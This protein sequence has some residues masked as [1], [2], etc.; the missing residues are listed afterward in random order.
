MKKT[1]GFFFIIIISSFL[2]KISAQNRQVI[3]AKDLT[4]KDI[5]SGVCSGIKWD[6]DS[7]YVEY[8]NNGSSF[9][10]DLKSL[11]SEKTG[12]AKPEEPQRR[13]FSP[14]IQMGNRQVAQ[15]ARGRQR[16]TEI[17]PDG[18]WFAVCRDWN[19]FLENDATGEKIQV[20]P[21]G[22]HKFRY[23]TANWVYGE[24]LP[25]VRNGM[26]W[27][28]DSKKLIYFVFDERPVRDFYLTDNLTGVISSLNTEGYTKAGDPI[29]IVWLEIYD[30]MTAKRIAIDCGQNLQDQYI[31]NI[32]F[33]PDGKEL[34][35][36]RCDRL[37][38]YVEVVALDYN[39]GKTRIVVKEE[40][41]TWQEN[42]P[43]MEY[44]SD[45]KRFIWLTEK[46]MW[47]NFE[48]RSLDGQLINKLTNNNYP[49]T[50][51]VKI[52]EKK[53][54]LYYKACSESNPLIEQ[55]FVVGL[56]GKGQKKISD[57]ALNYTRINFSPDNDYY[58]AQ[59]E[60]INTPPSTAL[61]SAEGKLLKVLAEGPAVEDNLTELFTFKSNDGKFDIYGLLHKPKSF[62]PSKK[63]PVI[64]SVYGG[65]DS[66]AIYNTFKNGSAQYGDKEYLMVQVDNRG[67]SGRGKAFKAAVYR[68]L[69]DVDIQDQADAIR[70]LKSRPY[71]K[72]DKIGIV[73]HSY[74]GFM[75]ALGI[76][77]HP[78]VFTAAVDRAG[79]THWKNY[80]CIYTERF[81]DL[82]VNNFDGYENGS[83]M[84]YVKDLKGKLLIMHGMVDDNVHPN[85]AWQLIDALD[86]A[87]KRY[88][89]RFFPKGTHGF[90]GTDTQWEFFDKYLKN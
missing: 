15:P 22:N 81:M 36:N 19:V 24:E 45:G 40:Q 67:T 80:D 61:Y 85:N 55:L 42:D 50:S 39:T 78:D 62:D 52:D 63:Y 27:T 60:N 88:E 76:L 68:K 69:G 11:E 48:L 51:I 10:L 77:R 16:L 4:Q 26:W 86:K 23:G 7:K 1:F 47:D 6:K 70:Y 20:T 9:R 79:P 25:N 28:P 57:K 90:D 21:D 65:P 35:F 33:T 71:V 83:A 8:A 56:D 58:I 34:L 41:Q 66:R 31:Y 89:S 74:G 13:N 49:V 82:P 18:E 30:L 46:N 12:D 14:T 43:T 3:K 84:K 73:G 38:R 75:A 72:N 44:L 37:Q 59:Y 54:L 17:S 53:N 2:L 64:V 32:R 29:P 5:N 87:N